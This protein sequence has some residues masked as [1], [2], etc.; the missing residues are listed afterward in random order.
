MSN[1]PFWALDCKVLG[2]IFCPMRHQAI[3]RCAFKVIYCFTSNLNTASTNSTEMWNYVN[4]CKPVWI[5]KLT[6]LYGGSALALVESEH[7][8]CGARVWSKLSSSTFSFFACPLFLGTLIYVCIILRL[9]GDLSSFLHLQ[10]FLISIL[11]KSV[12]QI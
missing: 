5:Q 8:Q 11:W 12:W 10:P 9:F 7:R 3:T 4:Y 2:F 6:A 1:L